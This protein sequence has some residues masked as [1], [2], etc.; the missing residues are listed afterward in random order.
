MTDLWRN[1]FNEIPFEKHFSWSDNFPPNQTEEK[2]PMKLRV[3]RYETP[4]AEIDFSRPTVF[5]AGPTVRGNQTHLTSWRP[6]AVELFEKKGFEGNIIIPEFSI[7]TESDKY[8]YDLPQWEFGGLQGSTVN[9]FWIPRTRELI[10]LTTNHE[11]GYWMARE[12]EKVVYGRPDD[13]Y[14]MTYL[15]IMWVED[16]KRRRS[17]WS[18]YTPPC[19]IYN[20]LEKTVDATL[21]MVKEKLAIAECLKRLN[22]DRAF[23]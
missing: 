19:P 23:V 10:G 6:A 18:N 2:A 1:S 8:R 11:H 20:T 22:S 12:R 13:A 4:V 5:L 14:R 7:N 9:M 3:I 21:K 16:A 15:D 17:P